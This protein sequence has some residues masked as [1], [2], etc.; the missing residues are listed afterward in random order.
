MARILLVEDDADVQSV[1]SEFL[2]TI[3]YQVVSAFSARQARDVIAA[4][5]IDLAVI[6]C[7]MSGEQGSSL[8]ER[9]HDLGIPTVMTSGDPHY[10]KLASDGSRPFL[11][12][13]FRL[14]ELS[15]LISK[16]LQAQAR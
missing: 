2:A 9:F 11:A 14:A 12:K 6:D 4:G 3:G 15:E 8:A 13:P 5:P 1:V 10:L 7:L 16:V